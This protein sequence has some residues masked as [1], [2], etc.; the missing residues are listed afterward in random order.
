MTE[1][2][3]PKIDADQVVALASELTAIPSQAS[4]ELAVAEVVYRELNHPRV[5]LHIEEVVKGRA[6]VVARVRGGG[7]RP[8]LVLS[9]HLDASVSERWS[10]DPYQPWV[11][12]GRLYGAGVD[13]M[14]A[15]VAAM[16]LAVRAAADHRVPMRGDLILHAVMHHDTIGLGEKYVL[17]SEGPHE[18][19]AICGEPSSLDINTANGGALKFSV[20]FR[21]ETAHV[22]RLEGARDAL[23]AAVSA[24]GAVQQME[25]PFEPCDRLPHLPRKVIGRLSGG[26]DPGKVAEVA[27]FHGDIRTV[28]GMRREDIKRA[29]Q[30][31]VHDACPAD[32]DIDVRITAVQRPFL[33]PESGHLI[34]TIRRA[35]TDVRGVEPRV[36]SR[37]P[38]QAFVTDAAD[39]AH[40][41]LETVVYGPG[42]W[43][44]GPDQSID[45]AE[46]VDSSRIYLAVAAAL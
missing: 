7:E 15:G 27:E 10:R 8:P 16:V 5:E 20:L 44:F 29:I 33:G 26:F 42:D 23:G 37:L 21:G 31:V 36:T 6:N 30:E 32:V 22:S 35:H 43:H 39:L 19:Y 40:Q 34:D 41:G 2:V 45:I 14:K 18:G 25:L 1:L 9:G 17:A 38:I 28:P 4:N 3:L 13:D 11:Q 24:Y 12:D 46:L